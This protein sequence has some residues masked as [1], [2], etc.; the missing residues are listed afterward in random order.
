MESKD[1]KIPQNQ[2]LAPLKKIIKTDKR[3]ARLIEEKSRL[4]RKIIRITTNSAEQEM[5]GGRGRE[6]REY[7][8]E[9][10]SSVNLKP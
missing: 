6:E 8:K 5:W 1:S 9:H 2:K 3:T 10:F 7:K 4:Q